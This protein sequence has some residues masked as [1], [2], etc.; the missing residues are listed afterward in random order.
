M[1]PQKA[2]KG[3]TVKLNEN[4]F[5]RDG[6]TFKNWN[7]KAD[8]SGVKY[9]DKQSVKLE[10]DLTLYAQWGK[11]GNEKIDGEGISVEKSEKTMKILNSSL[12]GE[13]KQKVDEAIA[14]GETVD[15]VFVSKDTDENAP[16]ADKIKSFA[17]DKGL[18]MGKFFDL[19]LH[20]T[21]KDG[22]L[23]S[24]TRTDG[25]VELEVSVP[26]ELR[27]ANRT[28]YVFKNH[29]GDVTE[30]GHGQG[31]S[32]PISTDSFSTYA[33]AYT[34]EEPGPDTYSVTVKTDGNGEA[35]ASP[36]SGKTGDTINLSAKA[37]KGWKFVKWE[38]VSDDIKL[39][40]PEDEDTSFVIKDSD[41]VVK[42]VFE[43]KEHKH[44]DD[45][46]DVPNEPSKPAA[47]NPDTVEGY[48]MVGGQIVP[49]VLLGK[50][51][52]G[53]AAQMLFDKT[54]KAGALFCEG[55]HSG[56]AGHTW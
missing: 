19:S 6:Y 30:V 17:K 13:L 46:D 40:D 29:E 36:K 56:N 15:F 11:E 28:F 10:T 8:G 22:E 34:D 3:D 39:E 49:N 33:M 44:D 41:V 35:S 55:L 45:D 16:G 50:M 37:D 47:V 18:T 5:T 38:V 51:K 48:F 54:G 1:D 26:E 32:V 25:K 23:G 9:D 52:Q 21:T 27:K 20:V 53:P 42:A 43:K 24:I 14:A 4:E 12:S 7:T 31:D 2:D